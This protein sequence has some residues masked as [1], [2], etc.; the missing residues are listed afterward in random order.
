MRLIFIKGLDWAGFLIERLTSTSLE[1]YM[2]SHLWQPLGITGITFW[3]EKNPELRDK[4]P[5]T[6]VRTPDGKLV[7][8]T[9][10]NLN[11]HSV[12]CYGGHGAYAKMSDYLKVLQSL[13][14]NDGKLLKPETVD[15]MFQPQLGEGSTK[16]LNAFKENFGGMLIG[17]IV[18]EIPVNYGLGGMLFMA[19][20]VGRRKKGSMSWGGIVNPFWLVDREAGI[21]LTF[22]TQVMPPGDPGCKEMTGVA[23]RAIYEMFGVS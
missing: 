2:A 6:V 18:N 14:A 16:A 5:G 4:V 10:D 1:D 17:E 3:P 15:M 23:E 13:L 7:P 19:D 21:A 9:E 11:T 12:D 22:G 8:Y 20:D